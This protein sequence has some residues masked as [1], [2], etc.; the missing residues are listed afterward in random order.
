MLSS[1][2]VSDFFPSLS[3]IDKLIGLTDRVEKNFKDLD[4]FYDELID[5]HH[6]PNRPKL[7]EGDILDLVLRRKNN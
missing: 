4:E 3:W 1:F 5:E 2:F 6:N 7:M